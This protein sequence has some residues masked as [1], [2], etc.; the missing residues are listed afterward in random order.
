M[1][2]VSCLQSSTKLS[3]YPEE[4]TLSAIRKRERACADCLDGGDGLDSSGR[5]QEVADHGF[6]AIDAHVAA[7]NRCPDCPVLCQVTRL[8]VPAQQIHS[9]RLLVVREEHLFRKLLMHHLIISFLACHAY[10]CTYV[11]TGM[12][13]SISVH[14]V[15]ANAQ[16]TGRFSW[17]F[18]SRI[19]L[20][21]VLRYEAPYAL[22]NTWKQLALLLPAFG[23]EA[24]LRGCSVCIDIVHLLWTDASLLQGPA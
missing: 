24:Y 19:H 5:A 7:R 20:K 18:F 10:C 11:I 15:Q 3:E 23:F 13:A 8:H 12:S 16:S 9:Q 21:A 2:R 6:C 14:R 22:K 4:V 1:R 17:A